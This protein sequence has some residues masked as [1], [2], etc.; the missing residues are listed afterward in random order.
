MRAHRNGAGKPSAHSPLCRG[1]PESVQWLGRPHGHPKV[2][3]LLHR[4]QWFIFSPG[5]LCWSCTSSMSLRH[6]AG[7]LLQPLAPQGPRP[8]ATTTSS[9]LVL[10]GGCLLPAHARARR[11]SARVSASRHRL[12][13]L[14]LVLALALLAGEIPA[15][16]DSGVFL[17]F[18]LNFCC[19]PHAVPSCHP[20]GASP[21]PRAWAAQCAHGGHHS[22]PSASSSTTVPAHQRS[23]PRSGS[24]G[25]LL[26]SPVYKEE[27][28]ALPRACLSLTVLDLAP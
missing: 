14:C 13:T 16:R 24:D 11:A 19:S 22:C 21:S 17:P 20:A 8:T 27:E 7:W 3:R 15:S 28:N 23:S 5:S 6:G 4:S 10:P 25:A 18:R 1:L 9:G 26:T 12:S 2:A